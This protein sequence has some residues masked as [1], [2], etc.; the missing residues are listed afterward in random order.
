[1]LH[2]RACSPL[3]V[4][5]WWVIFLNY[6]LNFSQIPTTIS[7]IPYTYHLILFWPSLLLAP[8]E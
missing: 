2:A 8:A 4:L 7:L 5:P 6:F 3:G 1:M